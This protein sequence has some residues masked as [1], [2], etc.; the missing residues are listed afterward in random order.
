MAL[1]SASLAGA[2]GDLFEGAG[3]YPAGEAD[4]GQRWAEAY[5]SYAAKA[6]AGTTAPVNVALTGAEQTLA[7]AL[8]GGFTTAKA[9]GPGGVAALAAVL[10]GA[11]VAF[12]L[13][14]PVAFA[15]PPTGP[16]TMTG[17]VSVAP[18]G[19]LATALGALFLAGVAQQASAAQQARALAT[20]LDAWTR[21][22][23]VINTPVI[24]PGPPLPPVPLA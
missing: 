6:V 4:A 1:S 18:P 21:T 2:L 3:G 12:W 13:A 14:P 15:I 9:A 16:P 7:R 8:A 5:R 10:D 23:L 11:F 20:V 22:V 17:I 19:V 24:P